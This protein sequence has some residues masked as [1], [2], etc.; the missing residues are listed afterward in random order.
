[1]TEPRFVPGTYPEASFLRNAKDAR[2]MG[3]HTLC[4]ECGVG[5]DES[6][7]FG[8]EMNHDTGCP[9]IGRDPTMEMITMIKERLAQKK[10]E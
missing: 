9:N 1:M 10:T 3:F 7:E 5:L 8:D 6:A 4:A 2:D